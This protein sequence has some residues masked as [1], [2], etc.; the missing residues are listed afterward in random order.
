MP[1]DWEAL[2]VSLI[3]PG[4]VSRETLGDEAFGELMSKHIQFQLGLQHEG[5]AV[6]AGGV[7]PDSTSTSR[8]V[9]ITLLRAPSIEEAKKLAE[10]DPAVIAGYYSVEV[11]T[12]YIPAGK[13]PDPGP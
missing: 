1:T 8:L 7:L 12:W 9:G 5:N 2:Y 10:T 3:Y 6:A 13:I 11:R 4:T